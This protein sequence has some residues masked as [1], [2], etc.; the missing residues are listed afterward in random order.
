MLKL[1]FIN[2]KSEGWLVNKK[3][4]K[5]ACIVGAI[6]LSSVLSGCLQTYNSLP[7]TQIKQTCSAPIVTY[8]FGF[9]GEGDHN[10]LKISSSHIQGNLE[11]SLAQSGCFIPLQSNI[12]AHK[13]YRLDIVYG[14][15]NNKSAQGGFF[16]TK[17]NDLFVF[18]IQLAFKGIG[19]TR[20]FQGKSSLENINQQYLKI[21]GQPA[22]L[23]NNQIKI[24]LQNAINSAINEAIYNFSNSKQ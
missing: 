16:H 24:T 14:S 12:N 19:E 11:K 1:P 9:L 8:E 17:T 2:P 21:F 20:I 15:I 10:D 6:A 3:S 4:F 13:Y 5:R 22:N 7:N 23:N 18:E